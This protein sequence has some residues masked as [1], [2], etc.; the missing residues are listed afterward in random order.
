MRETCQ[1]IY[2]TKT[3]ADF[4][5]LLSNWDNWDNWVSQCQ[6]PAVV[7]TSKT[8]GKALSNGN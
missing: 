5:Q 7:A 1:Q 2:Q 6:L 8:I 3:R 4:E